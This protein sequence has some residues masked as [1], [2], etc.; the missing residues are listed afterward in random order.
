MAS[1]LQ[2]CKASKSYGDQVLLDAADA[3]I[4]DTTPKYTSF[5]SATCGVLPSSLT[6]CSI[7]APAVG[8]AGAVTW[9]LS[10]TLDPGATGSVTLTVIVN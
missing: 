3:T 8:A 2:I 1:L 10:G 6:G 4:S 5:S 9:T 7:V